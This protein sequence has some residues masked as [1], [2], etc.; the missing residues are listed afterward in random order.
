MTGLKNLTGRWKP[1]GYLWARP[2]IWT[3]NNGEQIQQVAKAGLKLLEVASLKRWPL[4]QAA[5]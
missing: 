2:R 3:Q 4:G 5:S 1:V